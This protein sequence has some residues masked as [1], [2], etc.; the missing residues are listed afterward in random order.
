VTCVA[1]DSDPEQ[2]ARVGFAVGS[3]VG[4]AV[5]RNRARRLLREAVRAACIESGND[6]IVVGRPAIAGR[7]FAEVRDAL[8]IALERAGLLC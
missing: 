3:S 1:L 7:S 4:N 8:W 6:V 2:P 5:K